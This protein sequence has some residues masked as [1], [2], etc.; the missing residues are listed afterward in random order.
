MCAQIVA[1]FKALQE[2]ARLQ[3]KQAILSLQR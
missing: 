1:D 2:A 3:V